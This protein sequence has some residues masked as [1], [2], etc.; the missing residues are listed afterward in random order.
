MKSSG[1]DPRT[2]LQNNDATG[3]FAQ[4]GDLLLTGPTP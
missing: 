1:L 2:Y 4:T 3:F